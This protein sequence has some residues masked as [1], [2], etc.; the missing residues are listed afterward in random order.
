MLYHM[1]DI[2]SSLYFGMMAKE[3]A[4]KIQYPKGKADA[5]NVIASVLYIRGMYQESLQLYARALSDY[6]EQKDTPNVSQVTMN[7]G[8]VYLSLGDAEKGLELFRQ[9]IRTGRRDSIMSLAYANYCMSNPSLSD[10]SVQYYINKTREIADIYKDHRVLIAVKELEVDLLLKKGR[11]MDALKL[12]DTTLSDARRYELDDQEIYLLSSFTRF[13]KNQPD[14]ALHYAWRSYQLAKKKE[15]V[16][17]LIPI[18]KDIL[19]YTQLSGNKDRIISVQKLLENAMAEENEKLKKFVGDYIKYNTLQSDNAVLS[20]INK[21]SKAK[22]LLL[23]AICVVGAFLLLFIYRLYQISRKHHRELEQLNLKILEQN[24]SLQVNDEFKNK[25]FSI[26][27]HDFR[28]PLIDTISIASLMKD[29][30]G[31]TKEEMEAFYGN[32]EKQA[33]GMLESFDT[34]LQWIKQ[35][36]SGYRYKPETLVLYDLFSESADIVKQQLDAKKVTVSNQIPVHITAT[37]DKEML[38]FVNRNLL[39]NAIK[40][41]PK[42]GTIVISCTQDSNSITVS[43]ADQGQGIDELTMSKLFSVSSNFGSSTQHGAGIALSMCKDFIQKLHG[44]IWAK[45][46]EPK[47]AVFMYAIPLVV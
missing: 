18:L 16:L 31:F 30:P 1:K 23:I 27:A 45:N 32:I 11:R 43:V 3:L 5:D 19:S 8:N 28:T 12:L 20:I 35:Q 41:S 15:Y 37:S 46:A 47:G 22:I 26:L 42:G 33:S 6:K 9:V 21:N 14:S 34:I 4:N 7:M 24:K 2:D 40:F 36:L 17:E 29:N 44:R 10:D 38:Q 13:Y 39:S 25:L